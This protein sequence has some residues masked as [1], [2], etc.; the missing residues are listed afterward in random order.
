MRESGCGAM[1]GHTL[2]GRVVLVYEVALDELDC[3]SGFSNALCGVKSI[4]RRET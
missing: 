2:D 3:K 1:V 4:A